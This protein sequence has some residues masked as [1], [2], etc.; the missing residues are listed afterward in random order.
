MR[1]LCPRP[2][3]RRVAAPFLALALLVGC[4]SPDEDEARSTDT[5]GGS[6][7][8]EIREDTH[9]GEDTGGDADVFHDDPP[10]LTPELDTHDGPCDDGTALNACGGC[11]P[12]PNAPGD[13]CGSCF[14]GEWSC[15]ETGL[16]CIGDL[17]PE[18]TDETCNE[19][20][21]CQDGLCVA[22]CTLDADCPADFICDE[23]RCVPFLEPSDPCDACSDGERCVEGACVPTEACEA[24]GSHLGCHFITADFPSFDEL[25]TLR[26]PTRLLMANPGPETA[27]VHVTLQGTTTPGGELT[28]PPGGAAELELPDQQILRS[29]QNARSFRITATAPI[30]ITQV[31]NHG[32]DAVNQDG[33]LLLPVPSLGT[34][35]HVWTPPAGTEPFAGV[36]LR[37]GDGQYAW[38]TVV[39]PGPGP[40]NVTVQLTSDTL[41]GDSQEAFSSGATVEASLEEGET[42]T[43]M[44]AS[45]G[46]PLVSSPVLRDPSGTRITADQPVAVFAGHMQASLSPGEDDY[47]CADRLEIQLLP[48]SLRGVEHVLGASPLRKAGRPDWVAVMA[49]TDNTT[50]TTTPSI[51]GLHNEVIDAGEFR[52]LLLEND[53]LLRSDQPVSVFFMT[54]SKP[55][56]ASES[57]GDPSL[58]SVLPSATWSPRYTFRVPD[59]AEATLHLVRSAGERI[60]LNGE[61]LESALF[62]P[63]AGASS[64]E[65]ASMLLSADSSTSAM[66]LSSETPFAATLFLLSP[67]G[68]AAYPLGFLMP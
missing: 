61:A 49:H 53:V 45:E 22:A 19:G 4:F 50:L 47:C 43:F 5:L 25:S 58:T 35:Y 9:V 31:K 57:M 18:A 52:T 3:F 6:Q 15:H 21:V 68:A 27:T 62:S 56:P 37:P 13:P 24:S 36:A 38:F 11:G 41:A 51:D 2:T 1:R 28:L 26:T 10:P 63:H 34:D 16:R 33:S 40:T 42:W 14:S 64:F 55:Q 17:G 7:D 20:E 59:G 60:E 8:E 29:G 66:T 30:A 48:E 65:V 32:P 12:L 67:N 54:T 23:G 44:V 46:F 39:A